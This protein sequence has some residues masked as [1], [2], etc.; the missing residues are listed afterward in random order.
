MICDKCGKQTDGIKGVC[1][2]C[3]VPLPPKSGGGGFADILSVDY[4]AVEVQ[5]E[6]TSAMS[7]SELK[8]EGISDYDMQK[9]IKKSDKIIQTTQKNTLFGLIAIGLSALIFIS[10]IIIAVVAVNKVKEVDE[11]NAK[12]MNQIQ[13]DIDTIMDSLKNKENVSEAKKDEENGE[14]DKEDDK[15]EGKDK[16]DNI[17]KGNGGTDKT[18]TGNKDKT[19]FSQGNE[20]NVDLGSQ[21]LEPSEPTIPEEKDKTPD[22][23]NETES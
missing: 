5:A 4:T 14:T 20:S 18:S 16:V 8:T 2:S 1:S 19:P 22:A 3:G 23:S 15:N 7:G 9:L 21:E 11:Q 6:T 17:K 13:D 12:I 10:S